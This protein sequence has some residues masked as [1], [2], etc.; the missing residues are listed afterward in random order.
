[1][2]KEINLTWEQW[3]AAKIEADRR[4]KEENGH[5]FETI[6]KTRSTYCRR[7]P[8]AK[9]K[10]GAWFQTFIRQLDNILLNL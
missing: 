8:R 5:S 1:M 7:S 4:M 3:E 10:C 2:K 9:G 6:L